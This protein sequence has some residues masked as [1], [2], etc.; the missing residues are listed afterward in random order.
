[1]ANV[2][3]RK[4]M[5][6]QGHY[7]PLQAQANA[8][9]VAQIRARFGPYI[10][11]AARLTNVPEPVI[12]A[13]IY[14]ESA[15]DASAN[16]GSIGLMQIDHITASEAIYLEKK[17]GRLTEAEKTVL[18]RFLGARL[19]CILKQKSRGQRLAC[20][21]QTGVS[22]KRSELL[23]PEFN[24]LCGSI[25]L[26]TLINEETQNGVLRLDKVVA[27][28]NRSYDYRPV[29]ATADDVIDEVP[30]VTRAYIKKLVGVNGLLETIA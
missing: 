27:R 15:G 3:I 10:E 13:F 12:T 24:I 14:I 18:Y 5:T 2:V 20:N 28:Y 16:T 26:A 29:G 6:E 23:N 8:Q 11:A 7:T 1:M 22:I 19:D 25:Y 30:A 9:A 4:R 17:K 21:N